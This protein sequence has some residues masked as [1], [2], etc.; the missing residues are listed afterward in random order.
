M[1]VSLF[2]IKFGKQTCMLR[3]KLHKNYI[4]I[5]Q[6]NYNA[7]ATTFPFVTPQIIRDQSTGKKGHTRENPL[8]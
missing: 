2:T 1:H 7:R 4:I 3:K 6:K 5:C 8:D